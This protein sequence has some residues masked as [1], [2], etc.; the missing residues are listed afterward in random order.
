MYV[1]QVQEGVIEYL[2]NPEQPWMES[3]RVV[4]KIVLLIPEATKTL[5]WT[6]YQSGAWDLGRLINEIRKL[7]AEVPQ[8]AT[9]INVKY[10]E[11]IFNLKN[12]GYGIQ[13]LANDVKR[14]VD[15]NP[16]YNG[17]HGNISYNLETFHRLYLESK[18]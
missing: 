6:C 18:R 8:Y 10:V 17:I 1:R 15:S 14:I 9:D 2:Q 4:D 7:R 11:L 5:V 12:G 3:D 13:R 16:Q